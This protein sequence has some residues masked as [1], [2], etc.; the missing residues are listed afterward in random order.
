MTVNT[1]I[2]LWFFNLNSN[3]LSSAAQPK[4]CLVC[5]VISKFMFSFLYWWILPWQKPS[6]ES[7]WL[8]VGSYILVMASC[9]IWATLINSPD[10]AFL[11]CNM[12]EIFN[13]CLWVTGC[14]RRL[15]RSQ[16]MHAKG[17]QST[18]NLS[19]KLTFSL[20]AWIILW[21]YDPVWNATDTGRLVVY[22]WKPLALR[23]TCC[24]KSFQ[25]QM[26]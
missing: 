25:S 3:I 17:L 4:M 8:K 20:P 10:L 21:S 7:I 24:L 1:S 16:H 12:V 18:K 14:H 26:T 6:Q 9:V 23:W 15:F 11:L 19:L 22:K 5:L 2:C 13:V